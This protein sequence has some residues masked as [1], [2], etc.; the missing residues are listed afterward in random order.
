MSS[1]FKPDEKYTTKWLD[2]EL[3]YALTRIEKLEK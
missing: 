1:S 2:T 3:G